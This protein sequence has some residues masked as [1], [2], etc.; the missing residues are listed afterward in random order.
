MVS[1]LSGLCQAKI[2]YLWTSAGFE[3]LAFFQA[4]KFAAFGMME[5]WNNRIAGNETEEFYIPK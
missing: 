2:K 5:Y 4:L 3:L 1:V